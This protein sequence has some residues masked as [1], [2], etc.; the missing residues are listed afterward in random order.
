MD[1]FPMSGA[2]GIRTSNTAVG[3]NA[4]DDVNAVAAL[5][6]DDDGDEDDNS[7]RD[8]DDESEAASSQAASGRPA[9]VEVVPGNVGSGA[10]GGLFP[11]TSSTKIKIEFHG[12]ELGA[13]RGLAKVR[14][15]GQPDRILDINAMLVEQRLELVLPE[16]GGQ[17]A[18][19]PFGTLHFGME[20]KFTTLLVNN[21]PVACAYNI[22]LTEG[23]GEEGDEAD[24]SAANASKGKFEGFFFTVDTSSV[25]VLLLHGITPSIICTTTTTCL[26]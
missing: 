24:G 4:A 16:G 1:D 14:L 9:G 23:E 15:T 26:L 13:F 12:E 2:A 5:G 7:D 22:G 17:V 3:G 10:E 11:Q 6:G 18:T 8:S 19:L 20:K 21:G 25:S